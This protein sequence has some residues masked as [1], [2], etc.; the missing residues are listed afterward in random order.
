MPDPVTSESSTGS[1][2]SG[3]T[4]Q[5]TGNDLASTIAQAVAA[6]VTASL[7]EITNKLNQISQNVRNTSTTDD[8]NMEVSS[9]GTDDAFIGLRNERVTQSGIQAQLLCLV[10]ASVDHYVESNKASVAGLALIGAQAGR[11]G[12][13][14]VARHWGTSPATANP[15][16]SPAKA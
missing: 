4:G 8:T 15:E 7:Q 13:L 11:H 16:N 3:S 9:V 14:A 2:A 12:D 5:Q 1:A 6:A 10:A